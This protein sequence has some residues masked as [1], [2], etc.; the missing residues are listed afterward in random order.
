MLEDD[1]VS[2]GTSTL[3]AGISATDHPQRLLFSLLSTTTGSRLV[4]SFLYRNC[5]F[6]KKEHNIFQITS[7]FNYLYKIR[8]YSEKKT[9]NF[10]KR[11]LKS[12]FS[13]NNLPEIQFICSQL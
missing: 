11:Q 7:D 6:L 8:I 9:H 4:V 10:S 12:F 13:P 5:L 1:R 2:R 3:C